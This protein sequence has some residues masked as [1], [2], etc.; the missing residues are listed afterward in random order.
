MAHLVISQW[1]VGYN[2]QVDLCS[3]RGYWLSSHC[4]V[5]H[6][7]S[8]LPV[9]QVPYGV[10]GNHVARSRRIQVSPNSG[11]RVAHA[12]GD[13]DVGNVSSALI[14]TCGNAIDRP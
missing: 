7:Q 10:G 2:P 9:W 5:V 4:L 14:L 1:M 3:H 6:G 13:S 12:L 8:V 11:L